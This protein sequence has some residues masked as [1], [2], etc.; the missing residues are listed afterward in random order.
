MTGPPK[1]LTDLG[2]IDYS[3]SLSDSNL[4]LYLVCD[5]VYQSYFTIYIEVDSISY[6][7]GAM[8]ISYLSVDPS[9]PYTF[10]ISYFGDVT[11]S[12]HSRAHFS[13]GLSPSHTTS[14]SQLQRATSST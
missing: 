2:I 11:Y 14:I 4:Y 8:R 7:M 12:K 9:Y 1:Y 13:K 10:S 5:S 3:F 6:F